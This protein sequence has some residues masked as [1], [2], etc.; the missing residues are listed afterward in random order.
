MGDRKSD[1][2]KEQGRWRGGAPAP[3]TGSAASKY[4][5]P[6]HP[7]PENRGIFTHLETRIVH[8]KSP[9]LASTSDSHVLW[10][11]AEISDFQIVTF[12]SQA[13]TKAGL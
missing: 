3:L 1:C 6:Q 7:R 8:N 2:Y 11:G 9:G 5:N 12:H 4:P 10:P 13:V